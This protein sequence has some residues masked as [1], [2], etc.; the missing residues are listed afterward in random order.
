MELYRQTRAW[1]GLLKIRQCVAAPGQI[2][3]QTVEQ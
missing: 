3:G 2:Q 1:L